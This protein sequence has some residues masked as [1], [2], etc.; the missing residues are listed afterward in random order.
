[1]YFFQGKEII[2]HF[3]NEL[4]KDDVTYI[5][6]WSEPE[7]AVKDDGDNNDDDY[8]LRYSVTILEQ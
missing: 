7:K 8:D 1:M 4:K 2:E 3:I 5:P 6:P